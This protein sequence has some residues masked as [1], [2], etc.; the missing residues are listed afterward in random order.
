MPPYQFFLDLLYPLELRRKKM[1]GV[2][3]YYLDDKMIVA[4]REK[5]KNPVG[6]WYLD[7][8]QKR[9]PPTTKTKTL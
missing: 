8:Y 2:D 6:Q 4:L 1:F 7:R 5:E 9:T 3:A